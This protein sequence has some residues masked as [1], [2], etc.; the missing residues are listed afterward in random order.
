MSRRIEKSR[1]WNRASRSES[2]ASRGPLDARGWHEITFTGEYPL[3]VVTYTD[4]AS[5]VSVTL[6]AYS[7]FIPLDADDS[8]LP[9]TVC[10]FALTNTSDTPVEAEMAGWLE[11]ACRLDSAA[12][13]PGRRANTV[14]QM[15]GAT[16][17]A[18][19]FEPPAPHAAR[20][21]PARHRGRRL[22][23]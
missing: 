1:R 23:A 19:R 11:N 8:G 2:T 6:T 22:R 4:P 15:A 5:P 18:A 3:G 13:T 21:G 10:E 17:V 14:R 16:V 20:R 9:A 7:P 12:L